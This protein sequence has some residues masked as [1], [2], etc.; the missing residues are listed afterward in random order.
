LFKS[1]ANE[2]WSVAAKELDATN[3]GLLGGASVS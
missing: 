3:V 2:V 1:D